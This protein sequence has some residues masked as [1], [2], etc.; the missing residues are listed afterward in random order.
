RVVGRIIARSVVG[1]EITDRYIAKPN[2]FGQFITTQQLGGVGTGNGG[3]AM[4]RVVTVSGRGS[5][6]NQSRVRVAMSP[7]PAGDDF[8]PLEIPGLVGLAEHERAGQR[9]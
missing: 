3:E 7:V 1:L 2:V 8:G 4:V 9:K 5:V 6:R